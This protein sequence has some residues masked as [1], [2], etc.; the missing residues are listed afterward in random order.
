MNVTLL[1]R[2]V[3]L[4]LVMVCAGSAQAGLLEET[5][6]IAYEKLGS[7]PHESLTQSLEGFTDDGKRYHGCVARLLGNVNKVT[8]TQRPGGLFGRSLPHC[9]DGRIPAGIPRDLLN[10]DGWCGDRMADGPDGMSYRAFRE[11]VFCTVEGRWDGGDDSDP[12][13]LP[14]PRYEVIVRCAAENREPPVDSRPLSPDF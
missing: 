13:Y 6:A 14:S 7:G 4:I 11:N 5:C 10:E 1:N 9:A 12:E 2:A 3:S 8:D